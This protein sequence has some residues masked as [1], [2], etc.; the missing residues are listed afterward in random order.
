MLFLGTGAAELYPN[1]FCACETCERARRT[2]ALPRKRSA[3]LYDHE[4]CID[5]GPDVLAASQQYDAPFYALR[6]IFITHTHEDHICLTNLEV[7]TM[8]PREDRNITVHLSQKGFDWLTA[9]IKACDPVWRGGKRGI[10]TL[11][12]E[13]WITLSPVKPFT[14]FE[15]NGKRV[16]SVESNHPG[17]G[18][19]ELALNYVLEK[20]GK[21]LLYAADT[22]LYGER[23]QG[24]LEGFG[25]GTLIM[26]GTFGS[27]PQQRSSGHLNAEHFIENVEAFLQRGIIKP[28]ARVYVTHIN[29]VNDFSHEEY[30]NY[31]DENSPV[32]IIVAHDGLEI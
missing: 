10:S 15:A 25:C 18:R 16:Y 24:A 22:G 14:W 19:D 12:D 6:D 31:M 21:R 20:D 8:T 4:T 5:F 13:G 3:L 17:N 28:D 11:I 1:P 7:L 23:A 32:K 30:Q 27:R 9:Y 29:Q 26:E 2:N